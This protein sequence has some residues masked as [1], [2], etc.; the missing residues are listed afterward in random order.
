MHVYA[1]I[2]MYMH[3]WCNLIQTYTLYLYVWACS[4]FFHWSQPRAFDPMFAKEVGVGKFTMRWGRWG[5]SGSISSP[6]LLIC[7]TLGDSE[8][9]RIHRKSLVGKIET[10]C[11]P[12]A[13]HGI[14]PKFFEFPRIGLLPDLFFVF[15]I[16]TFSDEFP[17]VFPV[18]CKTKVPSQDAQP[19]GKGKG[20][21]KGKAPPPKAG[22]GCGENRPCSEKKYINIYIYIY[23]C[24]LYY[25]IIEMPAIC[26]SV[27]HLRKIA[28]P[29]FTR[30]FL[31]PKRF[32][33]VW[34]IDAAPT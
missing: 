31:S 32:G 34:H 3:V 10:A 17:D 13:L 28:V 15:V 11:S 5:G 9:G 23:I 8:F 2:C 4:Q 18:L 25:I 26:K 27:K 33:F 24:I 20:G 19:K 14:G 6:A 1:C 29:I 30:D 21:G 22:S 7:H 12:Q 16:T